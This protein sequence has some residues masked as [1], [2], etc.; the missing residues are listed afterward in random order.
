MAEDVDVAEAV[1]EEEGVVGH[2]DDN[3]TIATNSM[4]RH[5]HALTND[6]SC[7]F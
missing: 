2:Q 4:N 1:E 5:T 6:V 3:M 7:N